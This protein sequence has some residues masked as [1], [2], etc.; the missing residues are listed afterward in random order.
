MEV[1]A[2][3]AV[4]EEEGAADVGDNKVN[5][6]ESVIPEVGKHLFTQREVILYFI[7]MYFTFM[8]YTYTYL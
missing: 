3:A 4:V 2:T 6:R 8:F 5:F 7:F 1:A